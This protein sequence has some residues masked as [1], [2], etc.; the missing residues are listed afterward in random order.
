MDGPALETPTCDSAS[1][2]K[3]CSEGASSS[4]VP[5]QQPESREMLRTCMLTL[6]GEERPII[7]VCQTQLRMNH[8][9][10]LKTGAGGKLR[11]WLL[12][13]SGQACEDHRIGET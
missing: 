9:F 10:F 3:L 5:W 13:S 8:G 4:S 6:V 2:D 7:K 1:T 12:G 11:K